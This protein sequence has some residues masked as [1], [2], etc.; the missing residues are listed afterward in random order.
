[1]RAVAL[2][3]L[4]RKVGDYVHLAEGGET[5]LV[6]DQDRVVAELVPPRHCI[7]PVESQASSWADAVR[8]GLIKPAESTSGVPPRVPV[9]PLDDLLRDLK[10]DRA[11]DPFPTPLRTLD[12]LH[13]ASAEFVRRRGKAVAVASYDEGLVAAAEAMGFPLAAV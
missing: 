13:L 2:K 8:E 12:A 1:M 5:V 3:E 4:E 10:R 9:V 11:L 6:T 7:V